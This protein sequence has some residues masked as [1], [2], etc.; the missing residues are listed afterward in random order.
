MQQIL[1]TALYAIA[2][3]IAG[4]MLPRLVTLIVDAQQQFG[5]G[6]GAEKKKWLVDRIHKE[7]LFGRSLL[8]NLAPVALSAVLDVIVAWV[9]TSR[10]TQ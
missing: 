3:Q 1:L 8:I 7:A 10:S 2:R 4:S 6:T 9:K 5:E